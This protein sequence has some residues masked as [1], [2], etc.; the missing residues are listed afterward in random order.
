MRD[1][2]IGLDTSNYRTSVALVSSERQILLNERR[3][4]SVPSGKRG[5]RQGDAVYAHLKQIRPL[6]ESLR[7][8]SREWRIAAVSASGKPRDRSDSYMPVFEV[9]D[10]LGRGMA[11]AM[12]VPFFSADHQRGHIRAAQHGTRLEDSDRFLAFHLSG[13]TTD[14]LSVRDGKPEE[15]GSSLDLHAGQLVDRVGV[16]LGCPFPAGPVLEELALRGVSEARLGCAME[17]GD[18][19][20]HLSGAE[21][22]VMRWIRQGSLPPEQ[23]AREIYDLLART[24]ARMLTAGERI[25]GFHDALICGGIASSGLFR[26][27]LTERLGRMRSRQRLV[28]GDPEL[29]G[30]NAVGVAL[31]GADRLR[32]ET[33]PAEET[34]K[35]F[36]EGKTD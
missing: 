33:D 31:I 25:T 18:L 22:Q 36:P 14:L 3:L 7:G 20:C 26:R 12:G 34:E 29:S 2:V 10:A 17:Q 13:G 9:G 21:S 4:L 27:M 8:F 35:T 19:S 16:A 6:L 11:A 1:A 32:E 28:F 5:L 24:A 30:D 15:L 23:I